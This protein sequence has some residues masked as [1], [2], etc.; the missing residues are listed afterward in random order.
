MVAEEVIGSISDH[1]PNECLRD[2]CI[3]AIH[4][5]LVST[6]GAPPKREFA[7]ITRSDNESIILIRHVHEHER[8]YARLSVLISY[9]VRVQV[10]TDIVQ[11]LRRHFA[12]RNLVH[13]YSELFHEVERILVCSSGC[14]KSRHRY[15]ENLRAV[16]PQS[17][18][19]L[20]RYEQCQ[21]RVQTSTDTNYNRVRMCMLPSSCECGGLDCEDITRVCVGFIRR[22]KERH[23]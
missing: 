15:A 6:I 1:E 23:S 7:H 17:I 19:R 11:V 22:R 13:G 8:T 12:D 3:D 16:N 9:I 21:S 5:H 4:R 14:A 2:A 10:V 18:R 20:Y